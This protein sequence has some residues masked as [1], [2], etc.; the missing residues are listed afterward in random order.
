MFGV[1]NIREV[2]IARCYVLILVDMI[3]IEDMM[4]QVYGIVL[5]LKIYVVFKNKS[6]FINVTILF[7]L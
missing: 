2:K 5:M 7:V 1:E 3:S 4:F 6:R